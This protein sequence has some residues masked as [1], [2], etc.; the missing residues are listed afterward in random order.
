MGERLKIKPYANFF[1]LFNTANLSFANR[2]G[3]SNASSRSSFLQPLTLYG[4]GFG[5]PVG[6]PFTFQFGARVDF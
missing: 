2:I 6:V 4:P 3:L 1:N 5:P